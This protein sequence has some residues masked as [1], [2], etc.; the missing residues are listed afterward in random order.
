[1]CKRIRLCV[2]VTLCGIFLATTGCH[3]KNRI[4]RTGSEAYQEFVSTFYIGLAA[5]QVGDDV[6]ADSSL[7]RATEVVPGEPAGWADWGI[8][9]LRQRNFDVAGERL[10]HAHQLAPKDDRI[11]FLLGLLEGARGNSD[12]AIADLRET[13]RQN[14]HNLRAMYRLTVE[15]ER[16]GGPNSDAD[17]QTLLDQILKVQPDNL[18]V[19]L[20]LCR[21]SAKRG[22]TQTLRATV[23][24]IA[25]LSHGRPSDNLSPQ[26]AD[27]STG[28]SREP[29][30]GGSAAWG[31]GAAA[32][33]FR[34]A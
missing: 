2:S 25:E 34:A 29:V 14:P 5:L 26:R 15:I 16:Q 8:L 24:R 23:T 18:A 4:P 17:I 20:A 31:R 7:A 27:A 10:K 19:Q 30:R 13:I 33:S 28:V 1:M 11:D 32:Q 12:A 6:R 3:S 22:D 21:V 9:A